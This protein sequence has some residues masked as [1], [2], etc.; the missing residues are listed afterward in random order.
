MAS[1]AEPPKI[2][3]STQDAPVGSPVVSIDDDEHP[4]SPTLLGAGSPPSPT[5]SN[6]SIRFQ[7]TTDLR[8]NQPTSQ[9]GSA[10]LGLLGPNSHQR[11]GSLSTNPDTDNI[12]LTPFS[13]VRTK[14]GAESINETSE[15]KPQDAPAKDGEGKPAPAVSPLLAEVD[16]PTPYAFKPNVLANLIA[17][18]AKDLDALEQMG[19]ADELVRGLGSDR[20]K[21]L[22]AE[23]VA[24]GDNP[25]GD[26]PADAF[27]APLAV[28]QRIY[29]QNVLPTR[30]PKSLWLLMWL[31]LKDKVLILLMIAAAVSLALG[32][33]SDFGTT[34]E[35][36]TCPD[37]GLKECSEP[38][39]EWVEGVAILIAVMIVVLVGSLNDWQKERQFRALNDQK[40]DRTVKVI[41]NGQETVINI[42]DIVVGDIALVEPGEIL[43]VDGVFLSGHN[44][45]CDESGATGESHTIKKITYEDAIANKQKGI[46]S[47]GDCFFIS[48]SKILEGV[49]QYVVVAIG[50]RSFNGRILM[51]L[52]GETEN[53]PLQV[54]LN[55][56]AELIAKLGSL[57]GLILFSA[58]MIRFFVHLK[59]D[60]NRS[61]NTKA[62]EFVNIL[63]IAVTVIVVAVPEGL[64]LAVTLALAFATKRMTK[65]MLLV[66]VLGSCEI[67]ANAS[68][69][70]T[71]KT[72]TLTTNVMSV[73]AGSIGVHGKFA[74]DKDNERRNVGNVEGE[75]E[76]NK[77]HKED[78]AMNFG[79]INASMNDATRG[80]FNDAITINSTAFEDKNPKTEELEFVGSKTEVALL[81]FAKQQGWANYRERRE[82]ASVVQMIPFSSERKSMG[83]V[84][85]NG[86]KFR[87][88][89]KGASEIV[90]NQCLSHI[91]VHAPG[92]SSSTS[93]SDIPVR[94]ISPIEREN[95]SRTIIFY[96]NQTLRTIAIAYRDLEQWPPKGS[97]LNESQ[98]VP[99]EDLFE[100]LT[101][102]AIT[103]IE[104]PL[105]EGVKDAVKDCQRAGVSV[106]MCTGDN[107]LTARSIAYQCGIFTPGGVIMEGPTFRNLTDA[108][109][110]EIVP[111]LQVLARSSPEDK[112]IL[113]EKLK[114]L[115]EI[116]GVT[117]DGTND[118]PALKTANVGFSMGIAGTEVAKEASDII[119][120][121]DN[122][123]SIV[124]AIVWGRT[125]NDAVRKFLQFQISVNITA[126]IITFVT[127]VASSSESSVLTAV[128]L[129]WINIIMDTFA[130]L[131]LATDPAARDVLDRK[132]ERKTAPLFNT[133]M[134]MQILGQSMYQTFIIL[135]FHFAGDIIFG[136]DKSTH[137]EIQTEQWHAELNTLVFN[138]FVF[139][140]I[141]NSINSRRIDSKKNVF[142]GIHKNF[143]F[144]FITLIEVAAQ[145]T[146]V[147]VGGAAFS[148][149]HLSGRSWGVSLALGF[150][151]L[152]L[153]FLIRLIPE[154]PVERIFRQLKLMRDS[155]VL[156]VESPESQDKEWNLSAI[157]TVKD[158]LAVFS[159]L[160][161]GRA[162]ASSFVRRS[163]S[164][165][166]AEAGVTAP[167]LL[168]MIPTLM[169]TSV[170]GGWKQ[171][172]PLSD[173]AANDPSRSSAA[174][175]AG[176]LQLHPETPHDDPFWRKFGTPAA[177]TP[178]SLEER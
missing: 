46:Q 156:P 36:V 47:K 78:F 9:S 89:F 72:G 20:S 28:R 171:G 67:M 162:R 172:G 59:S 111:R 118:G 168:T 132:P 109:R 94:A 75:P 63:I 31:A 143:Y 60:P 159:Q 71:D 163:R 18:N 40:E 8:A 127:A 1:N 52:R 102:I 138:A 57:A 139:C 113:V 98:E 160:R 136:W 26:K 123:A 81:N 91:V 106:R 174:L 12:G 135:L 177:S 3:I 130:A 104:D 142:L 154:E 115:G 129:L 69:V 167:S 97:T 58:L 30:P 5:L 101:L 173:P 51:E 74:Q 32:L 70:C 2:T 25:A 140:Q 95:L 43:P 155:E 37:T 147:F 77:R 125:V 100:D 149:H 64:P 15:E 53:T 27:T 50:P 124:S 13:S 141:F 29:G 56:L 7:N 116:V 21:G 22:S 6:A 11:K 93:S 82:K 105:R 86:D 49:G 103:A 24:P 158:N 157:Q 178:Q 34:H 164:A 117:G 152:P 134:R 66:R 107:V 112:K 133:A 131:A 83:V 23:A 33:Y 128:Q 88:Y 120:M 148:V 92:S 80:V 99:F 76:G 48:G 122:F 84:V 73:V 45:V 35:P 165:Q 161:G 44:V 39:V 119:L 126:V 85:K 145:I 42:K 87:V 114:S 54:K 62:M 55:A 14:G 4:R 38:K 137:T 96:A 170:G 90:T 150:G 144:I 166:L 17:N 175:F 176:K 68:V 169:M 146:I 153:G 108:E 19:G 61:A 65:E 41:R 79:E 16:D 121:D 151:S 110:T 10:S